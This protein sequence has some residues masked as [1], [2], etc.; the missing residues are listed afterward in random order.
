METLKMI[1]IYLDKWLE[2]R[3]NKQISLE[4]IFSKKM[5][6]FIKFKKKMIRSD[7]DYADYSR[8]VK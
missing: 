6:K 4:M 1:K 8:K 2:I 5:N 3:L 7:K